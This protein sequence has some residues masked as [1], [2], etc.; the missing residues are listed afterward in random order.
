MSTNLRDLFREFADIPTGKR[1][2]ML[3]ERCIPSDV[4]AELEALLHYDS[5][6]RT[7]LTGR[8]AGVAKDALEW[9]SAPASGYCGPYRIVRL[10]GAGGMGAVYLAE[11]T[12]GEIRKQA[13]VKLLRPDGDHPRFRELF[14]RERQVLA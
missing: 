5:T 1:E 13:A 12:D 8:V 11:R 4:R 2:K 3:A 14:L 6:A 10:L 7:P 9:G